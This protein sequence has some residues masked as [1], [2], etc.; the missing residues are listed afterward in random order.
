MNAAGSPGFWNLVWSPRVVGNAL[1]VSLV[2]GCVLNL[3]NQG[4][5][6]WQGGTLS[7]PHVL[8]NFVVPYCVSSYSAAKNELQRQRA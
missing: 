1:R 7:W 2:V 4:P 8:L 6:W 3:I 5:V